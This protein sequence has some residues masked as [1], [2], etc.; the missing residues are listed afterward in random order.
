MKSA[1]CLAS[2]HGA[3]ARAGLREG[4]VVLSMDNVEIT[5]SKQF[6][7]VSAK[8]DRAKP[9]TVLVRRGDWVNYVVIRPAR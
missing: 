9:V 2:F 3:A 6:A 7:A 8:A 1:D 5:D 4:D